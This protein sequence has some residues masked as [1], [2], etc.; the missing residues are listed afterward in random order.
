MTTYCLNQN[1]TN[2]TSKKLNRDGKP[3]NPEDHKVLITF[4]DELVALEIRNA[5]HGQDDG[6][7][8]CCATN[9]MGKASD[10]CTVTVGK[11]VM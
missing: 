1:T 11:D 5:N 3:L 7:Y 8:V 9:K 2:N 6:H 4:Q 10:S